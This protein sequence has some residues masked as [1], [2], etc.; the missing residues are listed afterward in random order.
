[1]RPSS[2]GVKE[3]Q[4]TIL[5]ITSAFPK[6][7]DD[8]MGVIIARFAETLTS[9]N[10]RVIVLAPHL[11][12]YPFRYYYKDILVIRF[13]YFF[14]LKYQILAQTPGIFFHITHSVI[15]AIQ[16]P[17][18]ICAELLF[19]IRVCKK[20]QVSIIHTH[21]ILP[22]GIV[23]VIVGTLLSIPH[24]CSVH[25]TD[26]TIPKSYPVLAKVIRIIANRCTIITANS[27]YTSN[28]LS[29]YCKDLPQPIIIPMGVDHEQR[30]KKN[31]IVRIKEADDKKIV[32]YVGRLIKWKGVHVL[33]Q[34]M[35]QVKKSSPNAM[36]VIIG[37][38]DY[39]SDLMELVSQLNFKLEIVFTGKVSNL[40]LTTWYQKASLFVLPSIIVDGQTEGLGVVLLEAMSFGVPVIGSN[41]GGIPDIIEDGE[42]GVLVTPD[43]PDVLAKAI[44]DLLNDSELCKKL[45][46]A[47]LNTVSQKFKWETIGRKFE[48]I[49][50]Q[51]NPINNEK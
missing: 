13:P 7:A 46:L 23:G 42:N 21:W 16:L 9:L 48:S 31:K 44:V 35:N 18:L 43:K 20:E 27:G 50:D 36:L 6:D 51:L 30:S 25:G 8:G 24:I 12:G 22:H 34:A 29:S 15:G 33:V 38:G 26:V 49:Y 14:P 1:M 11:P 40:E 45:S 28:I 19:S 47:G 5:I 10:I 41:I 2:T 32:L 17:F 39:K 4:Q 3:K 37:D